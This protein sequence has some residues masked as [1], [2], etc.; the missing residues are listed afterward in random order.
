MDS[1]EGYALAGGSALVAGA[2]NALAG[3]GTLL[4]FPALQL[5]MSPMQA[6]MTSTVALFPGSLA[7]SWGFRQEIIGGKDWLARLLPASVAGGVLGSFL[8]IWGSPGHFDVLVPWL[9]LTA[10][11][12]FIAQPWLGRGQSGQSGP[13]TW[14]LVGLASLVQFA[15]AVYGGYF[16]AGIGILMLATLGQWGVG[17]LHRVNGMKNLLASIINGISAIIFSFSGEVRWDYVL[18]MGLAA[19]TGGYLA[20]RVGPKIPRQWL[21]NF[22]ICAGVLQTLYYFVRQV[23]WTV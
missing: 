18:V 17:G 16:G 10:S 22:V 1:W 5:V 4:T 13:P 23:G 8:L 20:G 21:R 15:V 12:L 3:G 11:V 7:G 19:V 2:I 6:N 9:V 14:G